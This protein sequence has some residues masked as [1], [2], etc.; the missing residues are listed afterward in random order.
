MGTQGHVVQ[1]NEA[2]VEAGFHR[3]IIDG[4]AMQA[5]GWDA[6]RA[7]VLDM[8]AQGMR[9]GRIASELARQARAAGCA[10]DDLRCLGISEH[11]VRV[12][13][14]KDRATAA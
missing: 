1:I 2:A 8:S 7:A 12:I 5:K 11:N 9:P 10:E 6:R 4:L 13:L 3:L 14:K